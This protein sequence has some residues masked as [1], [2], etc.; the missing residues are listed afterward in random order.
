MKKTVFLLALVLLLSGCGEKS[1]ET[2]SDVYV[3][4]PETAA[5]VTLSL[6]EDAERVTLTNAA[7]GTAYLCDGYCVTVSTYAGGDLDATL[8]TATGF[9]RSQLPVMEWQ[10]GDNRRYE[11]VWAAAGE[12]EDQIC[13]AV[14]LDD[15]SYHYVLTVMAD[16]QDAGQLS[17][18]WQRILESFRI[19]TAA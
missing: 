15:G 1:Y 11:C 6:P 16:A 17:A 18:T 2:V 7:S 4:P 3:Q 14:V 8:Q 9:A 5:Q 19:S 13:R 12:G 10:D